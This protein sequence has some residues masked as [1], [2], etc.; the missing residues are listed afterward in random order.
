MS[1]DE[2]DVPISKIVSENPRK[3]AMMLRRIHHQRTKPRRLLDGRDLMPSQS[4][5]VSKRN[6][7][8]RCADTASRVERPRAGKV[9]GTTSPER[10]GACIGEKAIR[11]PE[12]MS[13]LCE[14]IDKNEK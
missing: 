11:R 9:N 13:N 3:R 12:G 8:R 6:D 2:D 14:R 4:K 10:L 1:D 5:G 7:V